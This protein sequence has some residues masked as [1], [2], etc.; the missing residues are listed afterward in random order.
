MGIEKFAALSD[1][2]I[3][4]NPRHLQKTEKKIRRVQRNLS[5]KKKG[6]R[7]RI[8][9]KKKLAK[10]HTKIRNQRMDFLH[11]VSREIAD[12]YKVIAVEDLNIKGM[13]KTI[14]LQKG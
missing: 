7:N 4:G 6:S 5:R 12:K 14:T 9:A 2:S 11:K 1:G 13:V 10:P 3:I 8:K